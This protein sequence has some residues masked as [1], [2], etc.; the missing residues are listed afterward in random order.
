H[1]MSR[2][3]MAR[4]ALWLLLLVLS[5]SGGAWAQGSGG[6]IYGTI[7]DESGAVLPGATVTLGGPSGTRSTVSGS[8]GE[9][10]FLNL[11]HGAYS[12][13]LSLTGF[14][15]VARDVTVTVGNNVNLT[16][17]MKVATVEET[18]TVA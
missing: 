1:S 6:N 10:R 15:T 7:S 18:I 8:Q 2:S 16:F 9:F 14:S 11:D 12:L 5:A 3:S 13:H 4:G 17:T